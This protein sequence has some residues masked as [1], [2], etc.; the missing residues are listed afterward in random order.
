MGDF[1]ISAAFIAYSGPFNYTIRT[2]VLFEKVIKDDVAKGGIPY[3]DQIVFE[4]FLADEPQKNEWFMIKL[5][6]DTLSIQN[7]IL[8][9]TSSLF[10]LL[11]N[12]QDKV[13][14]F[15]S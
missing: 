5:P 4:D 15:V 11:I 13:K 6:S 12:P 9:T 8:V 10:L 3:N 2:N 7:A 14:K 1:D